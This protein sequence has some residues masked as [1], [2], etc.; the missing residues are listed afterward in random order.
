[1]AEG[2]RKLA[3]V[4]DETA[5]QIKAGM[6]TAEIDQIA[7][8]LI[9]E[10][11]GEASFKMVPGYKHATCININEEVVHGIPG[12][13]IIEPGDIVGL[14]VGFFYKGFHTDTAVTIRVEELNSRRVEETDKF[15]E[16]GRRALNRAIEQ[17]R[18][19]KSI[20]N[21]STAMQDTVVKQGLSV[22]KA[23][24]GH[25]IG[26]NLHE[27]PPIPCFKVNSRDAERK[28]EE[29]MVLAIEVMYNAGGED[30]RYKNDDGWT[31]VTADGKISGLFEHSVAITKTGPLI[32]TAPKK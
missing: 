11:G 14:D 17:A 10:E 25:G 16:T 20:G 18:V 30:V 8:K 1:M 19:G 26:R 6:T 3:R 15:L 24:T 2:G 9:R 12:K 23:L 31:I 32:L 22:V 5:G 4:R 7:D 28:I 29:G 13:R 21:I 27:E